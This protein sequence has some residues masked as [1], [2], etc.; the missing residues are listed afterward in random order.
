ME[1]SP[2]NSLSNRVTTDDL[3]GQVVQADTIYGDITVSQGLTQPQKSTHPALNEPPLPSGFWT[4]KEEPSALHRSL[5]LVRVADADPFMLGVHHAV[6]C[7][8]DNERRLPAYVP[9]DIDSLGG[10][11]HAAIHAASKSHGLVL[12]LGGSS[13]GKT[14]S[15][16]EAVQQLLPD[17]WLFRPASAE[18]I[19]ELIGLEPRRL[20]LWLDELQNHVGR[21]GGLTATAVRALLAPPHQV[22]VVATLWPNYY[23]DYTTLPS[24]GEGDVYSVERALLKLATVLHVGSEFSTS[25]RERARSVADTDSRLRV[26][27]DSDDFGVTQVLAAAPE[28]MLRWNSANAYARGVISVA[29]EATLAGVRNGVPKE[30]LRMAAPGYC[31]RSEK[32]MAPSD[33]FEKALSYSCKELVGAT[34]PLIGFGDVMGEQESF[35]VADYLVQQL[36]PE[37]RSASTPAA[38]W[39]ACERHLKERSD[40]A[41]V[42]RFAMACQRLSVALPLLQQA[43]KSGSPSAMH[44]LAN[45]YERLGRYDEAEEI[46]NRLSESSEPDGPLY[47]VIRAGFDYEEIYSLAKSGNEYAISQFIEEGDPVHAILLLLEDIT[48]EDTG[49]WYRIAELLHDEGKNELAIEVLEG[50]VDLDFDHGWAATFLCEL[51]EQEGQAERLD[52]LVELGYF[53]AALSRAQLLIR[54]G[55]ST[56]A[57][58]LLREFADQGSGEVD[59]LLSDF[60]VENDMVDEL[61]IRAE[62]GNLEAI[63]KYAELLELLGESEKAIRALTPP[64]EDGEVRAVSQLAKLLG[65]HGHLKEL[66]RWADAGSWA[67]GSYLSKA[68]IEREEFDEALLLESTGAIH[69]FE[70]GE[71]VAALKSHGETEKAVQLLIDKSKTEDGYWQPRLAELLRELGREGDLFSQIDQGNVYA[72]RELLQ[73]LEEQGR[74]SDVEHLR[75]FGMTTDGKIS[76]KPPI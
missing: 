56:E 62:R 2:T 27:L 69:G 61:I 32:A 23:S 36:G 53:A 35:Q 57:L 45:L 49:S 13:V 63:V 11:L 37:L 24:S 58:E 28:L 12:L 5:G 48:P 17:W 75:I 40:A 3:R 71:L 33:W 10:G 43:A 39:G 26:A 15:L 42:G 59:W 50:Y 44:E 20:V 14:R 72:F 34:A 29:V 67:A 16:Y 52:Q 47:R 31:N 7:S 76:P 30:L 18:R 51:L 22:V 73:L 19:H 55:E 41:R 8:E 21:D 60:L 25:E 65:K 74:D 54:D 4:E 70:T 64:A 1:D 66:R 46:T 6:R 68:L 38:F 9:R